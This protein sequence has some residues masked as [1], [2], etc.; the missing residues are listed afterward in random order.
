MSNYCCLSAYDICSSFS[1]HTA[2]PVRDTLHRSA[3]RW[4]DEV[5][6]GSLHPSTAHPS[7]VPTPSLITHL[8]LQPAL[9][10]QIYAPEQKCSQLPWK[11]YRKE[12]IFLR[13]LLLPVELC[14]E[15]CSATSHGCDFIPNKQVVPILQIPNT[16]RDEGTS[17]RR[18]GEATYIYLSIYSQSQSGD[19]IRVITKEVSGNLYVMVRWSASLGSVLWPRVANPATVLPQQGLPFGSNLSWQAKIEWAMET[20]H[21]F[22]SPAIMPLVRGTEEVVLGLDTK[23]AWG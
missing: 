15:C 6:R 20:E 10:A 1:A 23:E 5:F 11:T 12:S 3:F 21:P 7:P 16:R 18:K 17:E 4:D 13:H 14:S 19:T 9:T 22:C 2:W 8:S